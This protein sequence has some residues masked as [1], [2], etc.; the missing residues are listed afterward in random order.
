M[1]ASS[2][3]VEVPD[4]L[5]LVVRAEVGALQQSGLELERGAHVGV[6]VGLEILWGEN[7]F[8]YQVFAQI[9][10]EVLAFER[11]KNSIAVGLF[12]F[13]PVLPPAQ[14]RDRAEDIKALATLGRQ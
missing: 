6:E 10:D 13:V 5:A 11:G 4:V 12:Y 7:T 9:R 14:V 2:H 1:G 3:K 8:R